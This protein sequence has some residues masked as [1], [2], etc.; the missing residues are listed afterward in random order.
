V[1]MMMIKLDDDDDD[2]SFNQK[3]SETS[4]FCF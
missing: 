3:I 1:A 2:G 4:L